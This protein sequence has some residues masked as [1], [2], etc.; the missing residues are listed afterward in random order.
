MC[1]GGRDVPRVYPDINISYGTSI[2]LWPAANEYYSIVIVVVV[3]GVC[4]VGKTINCSIY[5]YVLY[6]RAKGRG[7]EIPVS[8]ERRG[9]TQ[10]C[11][12][13]YL[14]YR[15]AKMPVSL[16]VLTHSSAYFSFLE[17]FYYYYYYYYFNLFRHAEYTLV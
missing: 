13:E 14:R 15:P 10:N 9:G 11:F 8:R 17:G 2:I 12:S 4:I 7:R 16:S 1:I 6:S 5:V 3:V